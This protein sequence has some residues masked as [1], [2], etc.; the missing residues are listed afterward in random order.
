MISE[1][2]TLTAYDS[3]SGDAA[4]HLYTTRGDGHTWPGS[5]YTWGAELGHQTDEISASELMWGFFAA[6]RAP[7]R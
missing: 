5:G 1:H 7:R 2:V 3:C 6:H 4:V